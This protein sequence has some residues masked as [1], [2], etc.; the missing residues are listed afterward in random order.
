MARLTSLRMNLRPA[1]ARLQ[2]FYQDESGV[3]IVEFAVLLP[4]TL[5][6]FAVTIEAAR[7]MHA[8]Q[9][10]SAGV[11]D[12]SRFLARVA[13][14]DLCAGGG[15]VS[16][17]NG[18]LKNIVDQSLAG[19]DLLPDQ[20]VVTS[21]TATVNC[22]AGDYRISPMPFVD[23]TAQLQMDFPFSSVFVLI[24]AEDMSTLT[25]SITDRHRVFGT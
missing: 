7:M 5:M 17:F 11:R 21:V 25:T 3:A 16:G 8:Y 24:G 9:A 13:P 6:F 23:V 19:D 15:S 12:A 10:V 1:K 14:L 18:E 20:I 4:L 22:V 2:R